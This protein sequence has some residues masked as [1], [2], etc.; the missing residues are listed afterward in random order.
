MCEKVFELN[1]DGTRRRLISVEEEQEMLIKKKLWNAT[2]EGMEK[3]LE[4]GKREGI[5][6]NKE[7]IALR[8]LKDNMSLED[9]IKYTSLTKEEI[10]N[11]QA[12]NKPKNKVF[13]LLQINKRKK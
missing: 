9:I 7:E 6:E 4:K 8:M 10:E 3:G 2:N 5:K 11:I 12:H 1:E 13:K